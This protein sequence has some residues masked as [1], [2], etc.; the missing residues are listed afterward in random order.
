MKY[1]VLGKSTHQVSNEEW[2]RFTERIEVNS[3]TTVSDIFSWAESKDV[4][5]TTLQIFELENINKE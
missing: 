1:I 5:K 3:S 4:D 2:E